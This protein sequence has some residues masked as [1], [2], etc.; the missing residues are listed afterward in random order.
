MAES[1]FFD[2]E[3]VRLRKEWVDAVRALGTLGSR[4]TPEQ[5]LAAER[6]THRA[7]DAY[8]D[9]VARLRRTKV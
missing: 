9:Q 4:T 3:L 1:W 7:A 5:R 6:R 2:P 8:F